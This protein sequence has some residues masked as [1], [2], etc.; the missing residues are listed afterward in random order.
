MA[1]VVRDYP[2][3]R[4]D[5]SFLKEQLLRILALKE[6]QQPH[7]DT[8]CDLEIEKQKINPEL[9]ERLAN[10]EERKNVERDA[11]IALEAAITEIE[12][13][14]TEDLRRVRDTQ[15]GVIAKDV[16]DVECLKFLKDMN[17]YP[18]NLRHDMNESA[19]NL[20]ILRGLCTALGVTI[21]EAAPFTPP[22][23]NYWKAQEADE[24][25]RKRAQ[26]KPDHW[27][28]RDD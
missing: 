1:G 14:I 11:W 19:E 22:D 20:A 9:H 21:D 27:W 8:S 4:R 7:L 6:Q 25:I 16:D 18:F 26:C 24:E 2:V 28:Y 10:I 12:R 17:Y 15:H 5:F 23:P 13:T 3:F